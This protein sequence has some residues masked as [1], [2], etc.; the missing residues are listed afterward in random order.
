MLDDIKRWENHRP[1]DA[2]RLLVVSTGTVDANRAMGLRSTVVLERS[3]NVGNDFGVNGTP[4]AV[5]VDRQGK[6][7]S[8]V[9]VGAPAVLALANGGLA[10]QQAV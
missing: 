4:S 7:G 6:I 1:A 3:F 10:L 8:P 2:P 5:L 9:A